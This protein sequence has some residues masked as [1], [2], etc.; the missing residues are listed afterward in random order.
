MHMEPEK[1]EFTRLAV[2]AFL[3]SIPYAKACFE[4]E[5]DRQFIM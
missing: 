1:V 4:V 3:Y 2:K 5:G